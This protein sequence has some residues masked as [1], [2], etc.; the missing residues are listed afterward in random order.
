MGKIEGVGK[1]S[2]GII[3]EY[4]ESGK[5]EELEKIRAEQGGGPS[6]APPQPHAPLSEAAKVASKFM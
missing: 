3:K 4:V 6:S 2:L 5:V 1:G